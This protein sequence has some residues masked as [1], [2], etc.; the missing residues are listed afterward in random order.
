[1][2]DAS[3][4]NLSGLRQFGVRGKRHEAGGSRPVWRHERHRHCPLIAQIPLDMPREIMKV[5]L[6]AATYP[7][8][9]LALLEMHLGPDYKP[10][11][12][13]LRVHR[14]S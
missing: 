10:L 5:V 4:Y 2:S 8:T 11:A 3:G 9:T 14:W 1:M 12:P 7:A 13:A 6:R